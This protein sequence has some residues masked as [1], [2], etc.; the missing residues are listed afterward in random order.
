MRKSHVETLASHP[1]LDHGLVVFVEVVEE[2]LGIA[3]IRF[4]PDRRQLAAFLKLSLRHTTVLSLAVREPY[5]KCRS[6]AG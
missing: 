5:K 4:V 3:E 6:N 1:A 2:K